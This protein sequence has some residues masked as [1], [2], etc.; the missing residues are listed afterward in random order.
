MGGDQG[1]ITMPMKEPPV[2]IKCTSLF[3]GGKFR[4]SISGKENDNHT[5]SS[6]LKY[7]QPLLNIYL[8][9][10]STLIVTSND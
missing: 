8:C 1:A 4:G 9:R 10:S 6:N 5:P 2:K 7:L 3:I